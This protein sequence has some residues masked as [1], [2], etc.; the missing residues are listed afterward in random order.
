ML[1]INTPSTPRIRRAHLSIHRL[2]APLQQRHPLTAVFPLSTQP[3]FVQLV[4]V[5]QHVDGKGPET[6]QVQDC[7]AS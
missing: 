2:H 5:L 6:L 7:S 3:N 4:G 1:T